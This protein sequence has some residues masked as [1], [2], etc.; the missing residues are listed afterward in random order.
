[1]RVIAASTLNDGSPVSWTSTSVV[2]AV[3]AWQNTAFVAKP[4]RSAMEY[5]MVPSS[6]WKSWK[7]LQM[8]GAPAVGVSRT[9]RRDAFGVQLCRHRTTLNVSVSE[10]DAENDAVSAL[11]GGAMGKGSVSTQPSAACPGA[12]ETMARTNSA[13]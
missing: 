1:M 12:L 6:R 8:T 13:H 2:A 5:C 3:S 4:V 10:F 7:S 11:A 9:K